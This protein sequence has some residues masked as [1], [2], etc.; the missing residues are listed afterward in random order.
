MQILNWYCLRPSALFQ[1]IKKSHC[2][3]GFQLCFYP[4][5]FVTAIPSSGGSECH[6]DSHLERDTRRRK[7]DRAF[8]WSGNQVFS[9]WRTMPMPAALLLG[10][11][12]WR[13]TPGHSSTQ[14][15]GRSQDDSALQKGQNKLNVQQRRLW[16]EPIFPS[17][18]WSCAF[19]GY[20]HGSLKEG[21][22]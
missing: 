21:V 13:H 20:G 16:P 8:S 19:G 11:R 9:L 12:A 2:Q 1:A 22:V 4:V 17:E 15:A 10:G 5:S 3:I 14:A 18:N 7:A 6:A